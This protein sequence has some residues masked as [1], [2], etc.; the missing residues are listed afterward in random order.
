MLVCLCLIF[1]S[2]CN[3]FVF[4]HRVLSVKRAGLRAQHLPR[5]RETV[6]EPPTSSS[7]LQQSGQPEDISTGCWGWD[8]FPWV[9]EVYYFLGKGQKHTR[10]SVC[11]WVCARE[12]RRENYNFRDKRRNQRINVK[13]R[14]TN[15]LLLSSLIYHQRVLCLFAYLSA[16]LYFYPFFTH[17]VL[18]VAIHRR[19]KL[20]PLFLHIYLHALKSKSMWFQTRNIK[21]KNSMIK[22][23]RQYICSRWN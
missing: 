14:F 16:Y 18:V 19:T 22:D 11:V 12:R 1:L 23:F 2:S 7:G 9:N 10:E 13:E 17:S 8:V 6:T 4:T 15:S 21:H 3:I 20:F 5:A